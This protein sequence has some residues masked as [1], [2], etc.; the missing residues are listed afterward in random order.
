MHRVCLAQRHII[1]SLPERMLINRQFF[2]EKLPHRCEVNV[3]VL[4]RLTLEVVINIL[5]RGVVFAELRDKLW[6]LLFVLIDDLDQLNV[7]QVE[8][9]GDPQA[10]HRV[11]LPALED[12][13][14]LV[15][16]RGHLGR[17]ARFKGDRDR[18]LAEI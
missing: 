9:H 13:F 16:P 11:F 5:D 10:F 14:R 3:R 17:M 6:G 18:V 1:L 12:R 4:A 8:F 7:L 2:D 15:L